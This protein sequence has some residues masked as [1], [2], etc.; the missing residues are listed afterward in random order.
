MSGIFEAQAQ[1]C[2]QLPAISAP[3]LGQEAANYSEALTKRLEDKNV[4]VRRAAT[5]VLGQM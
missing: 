4:D 5:V 2:A 1:E 3:Q